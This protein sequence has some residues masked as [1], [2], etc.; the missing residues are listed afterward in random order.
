MFTIYEMGKGNWIPS[1]DIGMSFHNTG[2]KTG[3]VINARFRA[4]QHSREHSFYAKWVV[5][6]P[7]FEKDRDRN[8][9]IDTAVKRDWYPLILS[10][11]ETQQVHLVLEQ[12]VD[13]LSWDS[14]EKR[15]LN[16]VLEVLASDNA[17]W[18]EIDTYTLDVEKWMYERKG[19]LILRGV[20]YRA[21]MEANR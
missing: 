16:L 13:D 19:G 9:W 21:L 18:K 6:Y 8:K 4:R 12:D 2:E 7:T 1:F 5:D 10:A 20:K 3:Q 11:R 17:G 14:Q 15:S